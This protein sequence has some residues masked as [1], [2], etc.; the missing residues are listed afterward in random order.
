RFG[1]GWEFYEAEMRKGATNW[2][3]KSKRIFVTDLF[4]KEFTGKISHFI[5]LQE[6][7]GNVATEPEKDPQKGFLFRKIGRFECWGNFICPFLYDVGPDGQ[8]HS[9]KG[10][11]PKFFDFCSASDRLNC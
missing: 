2:D 5:V 7:E 10:A 9:V 8:W 1:T 11:G 6:D 4:Q 3:A